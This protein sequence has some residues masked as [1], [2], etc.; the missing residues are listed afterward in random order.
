MTGLNLGIIGNSTWCALIDERASVVWACVPSFDGDP[1]FCKLLDGGEN[2]RDSGFFSIEVADFRHSTQQYLRNSAILCTTLADTHGGAVEIIDFAPRFKHYDRIYRPIM[3]VRRLR[4]VQGAPRIRIRLRPRFSYGA[5]APEVNRG[6]NHVRYASDTTA[7]RVT[8]DAPPTFVT[9][10]TWFVLEEPIT[11]IFGVDEALR[12]PVAD[13]ARRFYDRTL[14]YWQEWVRYLSIPFEWQEAVIRA[15]IS[16]KLCNF[17]ETGGIVA[18]ATTSIP[19]APNSGRNWDYRLCWLR[20]AYFVVHALNRLGATRTLEGYS[21][22]ITNIVAASNGRP[23]QPVYRINFE[24]RLHERTV[25]SLSGYCGMGPV[26]VGNAAFTQAQHDV[27][28]SVILAC[29][30][31]FFDQRI[32][33]PGTRE[34][35][36]RLERLGRL[37]AENYDKPDAGLWEYRG[38]ARVHTFSS[39]MCWAACDRLTKIAWQ[40]GL[41]E[42]AAHW[43]RTADEIREVIL[44]RAWRPEQNTFVESFEGQDLDASLLLLHE[45]GFL[46]ADNPRFVGTVTAVEQRLRR[47]PYMMRY[48][49]IDDFGRPETSFTVCTFWYINALAAIGRRDEARELFENI[50]ARRNHLGLLSEDIDPKTG[51]LWGNFP[52]TYSMVGLINSA[53]RLSKSWEAAF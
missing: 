22:Y 1:V 36:D 8:T 24:S 25:D 47:G 52:Q 16:L 30:Q 51:T 35:F 34:H 29:T 14:D 41:P 21:S 33:R 40:L 53:M 26:R 7:L 11:L 44:E 45:L 10:E 39:V 27:Y 17:E 50:L 37:A 13:T 49:T 19:E 43:R 42:H 46:P 3:M 4:P 2:G 38:R 18:A 12:A 5:V 20:D 23:L 28:G 32:L 9:D 15:A 48:D 31:L 6:S